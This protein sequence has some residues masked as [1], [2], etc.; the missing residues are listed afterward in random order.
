MVVMIVMVFMLVVIV[1][2]F[3]LI[4]IIMVVIVIMVVMMLMLMRVS[5]LTQLVELCGQSLLHLHRVEYLLTGD[6][7]PR[8]RYHRR[9]IVE[10]A[11]HPDAVVESFL[12]EVLRVAED[13]RACV[14][15]LVL[16][17]LAEVL[18][19]ES[20]LLRIYD[21]RET[22]E[23]DLVVMQVLDRDDDVAE[24]AYAGRLDEDPL[25]RVLLDDLSQ[26]AS[27][28]AYQSA[29]DASGVHLVDHDS[30]LFEE[31]AVDADL[32]EFVFDENELFIA[33]SFSDQFLYQCGFSGAQKA[34]KNINFCHFVFPFF[35]LL[36]VNINSTTDVKHLNTRP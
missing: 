28:V 4:V 27:E 17:E 5:F 6:L 21:R 8:R 24:L 30:R 15:Y 33:V 12:I 18:H 2:V 11:Q 9:V 19:I 16:V 22:V 35:L 23:F 10:L 13:D 3:V 1:M 14:L 26:S 36:F 32:A 20:A 31:A 29:A 7:I 34:R 25:G